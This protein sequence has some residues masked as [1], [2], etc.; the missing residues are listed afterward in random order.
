[1]YLLAANWVWNPNGWLALRGFND[2]AGSAA[3]HAMGGFAALASAIVLSV[4]K[5]KFKT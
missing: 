2:F 3:V 4:Y 5:L 1:M